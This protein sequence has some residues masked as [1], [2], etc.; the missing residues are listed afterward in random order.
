MAPLRRVLR[1]RHRQPRR[2]HARG[3]VAAVDIQQA[4][5]AAAEQRSAHEQYAGNRDLTGHDCQPDPCG[6]RC[7]RRTGTAAALLGERL[8]EVQPANLKGWQNAEH[9]R[10]DERHHQRKEHDRRIESQIRYARKVGR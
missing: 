6:P 1:P 3:I 8:D 7:A 9:Q 10:R 5:E 2:E 4:D